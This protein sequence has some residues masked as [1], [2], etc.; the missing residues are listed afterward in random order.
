MSTVVKYMYN[1]YQANASSDNISPTL[2]QLAEK[3]LGF[4]VPT[5]D[6][7]HIR[8]IQHDGYLGVII[9]NEVSFNQHIDAMSKKS[10]QSVC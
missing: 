2:A 4:S 5:T 1:M 7:I 10:Y 8:E 3:Y 6:F 9:D